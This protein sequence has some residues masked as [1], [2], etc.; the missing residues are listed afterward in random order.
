MSDLKTQLGDYFD[1]VVERL[2]LDAIFEQQVDG[3]RVQ[4][5]QPRTAP[6]RRPGWVYGAAAAVVIL[7]LGVFGSL[8]G[9]G[10]D[11]ADN[12]TSTSISSQDSAAALGVAEAFMEAWVA[13][14]GDAVVG[15]FSAEATIDGVETRRLQPLR[16]WYR[17]LGSEFQSG[18]CY[19]RSNLSGPTTVLCDY[20]YQNKL[21]RALGREPVA[22]SFELFVDSGRIAYVGG[23]GGEGGIWGKSAFISVYDMFMEWV[24]INH[25][26][27]MERMYAG[28]RPLLDPTSIALWEQH[29]DELAGSSQA[30]AQFFTQWEAGLEAGAEARHEY[31]VQA[32]EICSTVTPKLEAALA[33]TGLDQGIF[34]PGDAAAV[35][36]ALIPISE[37]AL[38]EMRALPP[39]PESARGLLNRFYWLFEQAIETDRQVVAAAEANDA[40]RVKLLGFVG[41]DLVHQIDN[42]NLGF[43]KC[44]PPGR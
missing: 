18:G 3:S 43:G 16:D 17:A 25:P 23:A 7:L 39:P 40:A 34:G 24:L 21:A 15:M 37:E 13:G 12:Q 22:G 10:P 9:N 19:L 26:D 6:P 4:P 44:R 1:N 8:F 41:L 20:R 33:G 5:V 2:D 31:L 36:Q 30:L 11:V 32:W 28:S 38:A 29:T 35:S 42:I 27:D 14:D